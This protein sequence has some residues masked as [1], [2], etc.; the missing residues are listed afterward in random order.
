MVPAKARPRNARA[1]ARKKAKPPST[2]QRR[3]SADVTRN[4]NALDLEPAVFTQRS[5]RRIA[6]SLKHAAE[7]STRR[8][9]TAYQSAMSM[10]NFYMNR[11]GRKLPKSRLAVL[12]RAKGALRRAFGRA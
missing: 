4:S 5:P 8:K 2:R 12:N 1:P 6:Q 3:W 10:L 7:A 9:G 11:A